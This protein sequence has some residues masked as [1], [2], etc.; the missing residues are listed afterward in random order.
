MNNQVLSKKNLNQIMALK[1]PLVF[2]PMAADLLH[3]GHI[4]ILKKAAEYGTVVVGLMTDKGLE[5]YKRKPVLKYNERKEIILAIKYVNFVIPLNGLV[6]LKLAELLKIDYFIHGTDWKRGPQS[7]VRNKL[8]KK[9]K[10]WKG[11]VI[12][13]QYTK[14]ISS[15]KIRNFFIK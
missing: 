6:F 7:S 15:T 3:H 13:I 9:V 1:R 10:D 12:E 11:K 8:I 4:R 2:V 5:S 14:N